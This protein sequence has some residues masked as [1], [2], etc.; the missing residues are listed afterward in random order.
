[1]IRKK[2]TNEVHIL[3]QLGVQLMNPIEQGAVVMNGSEAS[4]VSEVKGMKDQDLILLE[5]K[6]KVKK[7]RK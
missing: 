5:L 3:S 6:A 7:Q 1:M 2:S 4:V